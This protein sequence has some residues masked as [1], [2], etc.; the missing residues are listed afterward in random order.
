MA[1][2]TENANY[3]GEGLG[4]FTGNFG[5]LPTIAGHTKAVMIGFQELEGV[6]W[7]IINVRLLASHPLPGGP[8]A[9][10]DGLG[11]L[12]GQPRNLMSD[13]DYIVAIKLRVAV[14]RASVRITEWSAFAATLLAHGAGVT[15][16][17]SDA[18]FFFAVW[19]LTLSAPVMASILAGAVPNG[20]RAIFGYSGWA[21]GN[22]LEFCAA[23]GTGG[24]GVLGDAAG[25]I[26]GLLVAALEMT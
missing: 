17:E 14:N 1:L 9:A 12:V 4:Y 10:L 21:R 18:S 3:A 11:A 15:Y 20:V 24:Q 8:W 19:D 7:D 26:G 22:D 13:A 6:F 25:T 16:Y 5:K 2:P 23:D